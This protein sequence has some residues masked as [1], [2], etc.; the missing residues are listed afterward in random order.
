MLL[1][2]GDKFFGRDVG[3]EIDDAEVGAFPHHG[4]EILAN[5]MQ[6]ALDRADDSG[7]GGFDAGFDEQGL[8][9]RHTFFHGPSGYQHFRN[10]NLIVFKFLTDGY[11][12]GHQALFDDIEGLHTSSEQLIGQS[13]RFVAIAFFHELG[14]FL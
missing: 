6:V 9:D 8:E 5:I 14:Q 2:S 4:H 1:G 13:L 11:H 10:K 3:A 12:P 7:K